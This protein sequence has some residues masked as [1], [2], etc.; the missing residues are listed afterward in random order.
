[1]PLCALLHVILAL[2]GR[3]PT[4]TC[5]LGIVAQLV[6][7]MYASIAYQDALVVVRRGLVGS[8]DA[9]RIT[10]DAALRDMARPALMVVTRSR[11]PTCSRFNAG[12]HTIYFTY[13]LLVI[14]GHNR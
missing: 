13:R 7:F 3:V 8:I 4:A 12:R 6:A 11:V 9:D 1:M 2:Q 14:G 10:V 5:S